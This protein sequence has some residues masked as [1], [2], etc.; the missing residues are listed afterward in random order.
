MLKKQVISLLLIGSL[1][2]PTAFAVSYDASDLIYEIYTHELQDET[3]FTIDYAGSLEQL[4]DLV[5]LVKQGLQFDEYRYYSLG[6]L[7]FFITDNGKSS[8]LRVKLTR[9]SA[10]ENEVFV[11]RYIEETLKSLNLEGLSDYWRAR[12]IAEHLSTQFIYDSEEQIHDP[13]H[14]IQSR[15]GVCQAYALLFYKMARA[16]GLEVRHQEGRLHEGDHLWN[17]VKIKDQWFHVDPT[18]N[19]FNASFSLFLKDNDFLKSKD[20]S[21]SELVEPVVES[22]A[23]PDQYYISGNYSEAGIAEILNSPSPVFDK[24][25]DG[26]PDLADLKKGYEYNISLDIATKTLASSVTKA[27]YVALENLYLQTKHP[28]GVLEVAAYELMA[29]KQ[30]ENKKQLD[31]IFMPFAKAVQSANIKPSVSTYEAALKLSKSTSMKLKSTALS[32]A[33]ANGYLA[34]IETSS[35]RLN[36]DLI[37]LKQSKPPTSQKK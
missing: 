2:T 6:E 33:D 12:K 36:K 25:D 5:P 17:V 26:K 15:K 29:L 9:N 35:N 3:D 14:M 31:Q 4:G 11:N 1:M 30:T 27:N 28:K 37:K 13:Y 18:N 23:Q 19:N 21:W 32:D 7:E 24:P 10:A 20:F 8:K 16:A 34:L 22:N